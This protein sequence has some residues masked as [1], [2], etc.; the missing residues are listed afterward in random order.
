MR[1]DDGQIMHYCASTIL[2][3]NVLEDLSRMHVLLRPHMQLPQ[4]M[5]GAMGVTAS[6]S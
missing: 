2:F 3:Q 4:D 5:L 1:I 6:L